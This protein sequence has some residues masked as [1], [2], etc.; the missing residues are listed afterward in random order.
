V[1]HSTANSLLYLHFSPI[2]IFST[3]LSTLSL[4]FLLTY[5]LCILS[6]FPSYHQ[7]SVLLRFF[8]LEAIKVTVNI[9]QNISLQQNHIQHSTPY[10]LRYF[11]IFSIVPVVR[12]H[13]QT[14]TQALAFESTDSVLYRMFILSCPWERQL[15]QMFRR[16]QISYTIKLSCLRA[17]SR[18][19]C[20]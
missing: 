3:P 13:K 14:Y 17:R 10:T 1:K 18:D 2:L 20:I 4:S 9:A 16:M 5:F 11:N 12:K 6:I 19:T 8:H 7:S 15:S